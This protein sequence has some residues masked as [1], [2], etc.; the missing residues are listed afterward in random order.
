[1]K[2]CRLEINDSGSWR[3]VAKFDA[4]CDESAS[5]VLDAAEQLGR[6]LSDPEA[7]RR[8][9]TRLRVTVDSRT[10]GT[11][12]GWTLDEGWRDATGDAC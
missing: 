1:M 12:M 6:A 7:G 10:G 9:Q 11:L 8:S 4:E 2:P 5:C 3:L